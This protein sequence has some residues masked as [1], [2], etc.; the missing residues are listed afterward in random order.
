MRVQWLGILM[1]VVLVWSGCRR[2]KGEEPTPTDN[3]VTTFKEDAIVQ[4]ETQFIVNYGV[5]EAQSNPNLI[6]RVYGSSACPTLNITILDS[7]NGWPRKL[8]LDFGTTNC[9]G[10]DGKYRRGKIHIVYPSPWKMRKPG[11][12]IHIY[13]DNYYVNDIRLKGNWYLSILDSVRIRIDAL[14]IQLTFPNGSQAQWTNHRIRTFVSGYNTPYDRTDDV[15]TIEILQGSGGTTRFGTSYTIQTRS[16]N[17]LRLELGCPYLVTAGILEITP[18]GKLTR[19]IDYGN[20][21]CDSLA[22]IS[23]GNWSTTV[24]IGP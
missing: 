24:V 20:G 17:P 9:L 23:I 2:P 15:F 14:N 22:T 11:D 7:V 18:Q 3:D 4:S 8:T 6:N 12:T 19:V 21:T 1:A 5:S 10:V 16:G 13:T